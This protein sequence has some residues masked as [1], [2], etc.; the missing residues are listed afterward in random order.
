MAEYAQNKSKCNKLSILWLFIH[1]NVI[2]LHCTLGNKEAQLK[3]SDRKVGIL[4]FYNL[5]KRPPRCDALQ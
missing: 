3:G 5:Q 2:P 1:F 4:L